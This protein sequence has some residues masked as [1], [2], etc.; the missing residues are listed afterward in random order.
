MTT[1]SLGRK[2]IIK[3]GGSVIAGVQSKSFSVNG[4]ALDITGDDDSGFQTFAAEG[5]VASIESTLSGIEKDG[6]IRALMLANPHGLLV[7][8][9]AFEWDNG[10]QITCDFWLDSYSEDNP[11]D[12]SSTFTL[13]IKSSGSWVHTPAT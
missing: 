12:E 4:T 11:S 9:F 13:S 3:K 6:V 5:G 8:D 2:F 7:T 1:G 10:E